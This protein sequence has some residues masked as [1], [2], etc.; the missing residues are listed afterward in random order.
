MKHTK[1]TKSDEEYYAILGVESCASIKEIKSAYRSLVMKYHPDIN[2]SKDSVEKFIEI[3]EAYSFLSNSSNKDYSHGRKR[4]TFNRNAFK[5]D[6]M[7]SINRGSIHKTVSSAIK[8]IVLKNQINKSAR[9]LNIS[10]I[11][12]T[13]I[14]KFRFC[15][16]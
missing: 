15:R 14:K 3:S 5:I 6:L 1:Y 2:H 7:R 12:N 13:K 10:K 16:L 11:I 8:N 4:N 9:N